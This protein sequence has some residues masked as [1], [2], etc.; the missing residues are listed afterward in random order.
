MPNAQIL[1]TVIASPGDVQSERNTL[2]TVVLELNRGIAADHGLR[3]ELVRWETDSFPGFH[4]KG[5]QG[6]IDSVLKVQDCDILIGIFWKRFGT[7]VED[8]QSGTEHEFRIAYEAWKQN[9]TPHIMVYFNKKAYAPQSPEQAD[10]WKKVL[11]FKSNF[12]KEGM[13]WPYNGK[14]TFERLVRNHLTQYIRHQ[15]QKRIGDVKTVLRGKLQTNLDQIARQIRLTETGGMRNSVLPRRPSE[16]KASFENRSRD[17]FGHWVEALA[18]RY[19]RLS[20]TET[21]F[22]AHQI[23]LM[24]LDESTRLSIESA[25]TAVRDAKERISHYLDLL[26]SL[27]FDASTDD[28]REEQADKHREQTSNWLK[29]EWFG[30]LANWCMLEPDEVDLNLVNNIMRQITTDNLLSNAL[31]GGVEGKRLA[32]QQQSLILEARIKTTDTQIESSEQQLI[33]SNTS[34]FEAPIDAPDAI[35]KASWAFLSGDY[36]GAV[37]YYQEAQKI[38]GLAEQHI[39]YVETCLLYLTDADVFDGVTG[40]YITELETT[41]NGA[42]FGLEAG[43]VII[44]YNGVPVEEIITLPKIAAKA[45]GTPSIALEIVRNGHKIT[46]YL[47]QHIGLNIRCIALA[48]TE[49]IVM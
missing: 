24:S 26:R 20:P 30:I 18:D 44:K 13:W 19:Q 32:F 4:A 29:H 45:K 15:A 36:E 39:H 17:A 48:Y 14:T 25:Y 43:D 21:A 16:S 49:I 35:G 6:L 28:W 9:G 31:K 40:A 37:H 23:T 22:A 38:G 46:K 12:P 11:E 5:P 10:Q 3:I 8:A 7:P 27:I 41:G 33:K 47:D 34:N 1:K 42:R 2:D